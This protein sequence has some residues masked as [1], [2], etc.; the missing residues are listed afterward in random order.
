MT[1]RNYVSIICASGEC[2]I[3]LLSHLNVIKSRAAMCI[4]QMYSSFK[5]IYSFK[6]GER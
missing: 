4:N 6:K 1:S 2:I 5:Y 3:L